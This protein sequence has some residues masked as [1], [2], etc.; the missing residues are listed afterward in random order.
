LT[1]SLFSE[2]ERFTAVNLYGFLVDSVGL[3]ERCGIEE[4]D[5]DDEELIYFDSVDSDNV[6]FGFLNY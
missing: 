1:F 4:D 5:E 3:T 2:C 6:S